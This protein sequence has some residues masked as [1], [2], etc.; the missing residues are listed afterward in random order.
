MW[1]SSAD[2]FMLIERPISES[3][4]Y[5]IFRDLRKVAMFVAIICDQSLGRQQIG[6]CDD[7]AS[8][9]H[10]IEHGLSLDWFKGT[11]TGNSWFLPSNIGLSG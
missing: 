9:I 3:G 10:Q 6:R 7:V 8:S 4:V 1:E 11:F 5:P 2:H